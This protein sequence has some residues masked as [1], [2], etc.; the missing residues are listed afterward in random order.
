MQ[1]RPKSIIRYAPERRYTEAFKR[2]VIADIDA[3]RLTKAEAS[4]RYQI[5]GH[6]TVLK[7]YRKYSKFAQAGI[8]IGLSMTDK[9]QKQ[10]EERLAKDRRIRELEAALAEAHLYNRALETMISLAEETYKIPVRK[11]SGAK[12]SPI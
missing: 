12:Q 2:S 7:W 5:A 3:G 9:Q 4:R 11:N 1:D 8:T 6:S 10:K